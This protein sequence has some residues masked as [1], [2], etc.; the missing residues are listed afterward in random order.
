[1]SDIKRIDPKEFQDFGYLQEVNRRFLHPLG[2]ALEITIDEEGKVSLGGIWDYRNDPIGLLFAQGQ[3]DQEK[4]T[5]VQIAWE[6]K[7]QARRKQ[8]GDIIQPIEATDKK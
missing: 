3:L 8:L 2:L 6:E 4:A 1:M 7:E 5:R